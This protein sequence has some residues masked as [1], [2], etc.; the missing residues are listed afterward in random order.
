M[1]AGK[2]SL[3]HS[4]HTLVRSALQLIHMFYI[5]SAKVIVNIVKLTMNFLDI[6]II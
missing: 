6:I 1:S 5:G 4:E 2:V 3:G